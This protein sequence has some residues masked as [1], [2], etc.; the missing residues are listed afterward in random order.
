MSI[1]TRPATSDLAAVTYWLPGPTTASHAS[2]SSP[3]PYAS[4]AIACAPPIGRSTSA[5]AT[6]AAAIV[7]ADGRGEATTTREQPATR[8]VM[9]VISTDEGSG[10]RPPGA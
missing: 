2:S 7:I 3:A 4:V 8:A 10:Y 6:Y 9:P 1:A 5:S